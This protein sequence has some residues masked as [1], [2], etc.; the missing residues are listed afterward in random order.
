[1]G[2]TLTDYLI[3]LFGVVPAIGVS[4]YFHGGFWTV[5]VLTLVFGIGFWCVVFLWLMPILDR[6]RK[7]EAHSDNGDP[8]AA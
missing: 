3:V 6:R 7:A 1:M 4:R 2:F 5:Y 8:P